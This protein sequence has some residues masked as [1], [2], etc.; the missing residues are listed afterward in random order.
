MSGTYE[1]AEQVG[2]IAVT[3]PAKPSSRG[4]LVLPVILIISI[5]LLTTCGLVWTSALL[6]NENA[7]ATTRSLAHSMLAVELR[8]LSTLTVD[9][10]RGGDAMQGALMDP[11]RTPTTDLLDLQS[12]RDHRVSS[13]FLVGSDGRVVATFIR[14]RSRKTEWFDQ[15]PDALS[16]LVERSRKSAPREMRSVAGLVKFRGAVNLVAA[17]PLQLTSNASSRAGQ[18][19]PVLVLA[20]ALDQ[21]FLR[22]AASAFSLQGLDYFEELPPESYYPSQ[23]IGVEAEPIGYLAW[24]NAWPGDEILWRLLPSL[25]C[26]LLAI[27]YLLYIFF[28]STD[29]VLEHQAALVSSLRR[30]REL[31][32]LKTRFVSMVSHELRTPL[33]TI[34]SA[35]DLLDRYEGR[36]TPEERKRELGAIR[37]AVIS[38]TR[39]VEKVLSL[40]RTDSAESEPQSSWFD[41]GEFCRNLW[42]ETKRA[43]ASE[44]QLVLS[45]GAVDKL[46]Y[47]DE[48]F[49]RAALSNL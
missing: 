3:D 25:A 8:A 24:R 26:S 20:R 38:V 42:H 4:G 39:M 2:R 22:E 9:Y 47:T 29:V 17:S 7:Q 1:A 33:S 16:G 23:L 49:L 13:S 15:V 27:T 5:S 48:T 21:D 6:L 41:L 32:D 37:S 28:R 31:R 12:A 10:A 44:H 30:E 35:A 40:G 45:G 14:D 43:M 19:R 46:A 18:P 34:R 11:D 36:M